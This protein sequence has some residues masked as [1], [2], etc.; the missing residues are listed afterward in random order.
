ME[1]TLSRQNQMESTAV[2]SMVAEV[3]TARPTTLMAVAVVQLM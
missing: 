2:V 1:R 3:V